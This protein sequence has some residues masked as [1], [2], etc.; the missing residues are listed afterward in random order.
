MS[1]SFPNLEAGRGGGGEGSF[2]TPSLYTEMLEHSGTTQARAA[3]WFQ[4]HW[5]HRTVPFTRWQE[6]PGGRR[7]AVI[8]AKLDRKWFF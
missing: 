1:H 5:G 8:D 3:G 2:S 6:L 4:G 7:K